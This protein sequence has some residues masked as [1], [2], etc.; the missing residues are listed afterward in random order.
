MKST[1]AFK[2]YKSMKQFNMAKLKY[3]IIISIFW[4]IAACGDSEEECQEASYASNITIM[5]D[6]I[7][8]FDDGVELQ[9]NSLNNEFC[10]CNVQCVAAGFISIDMVWT[11]ADGTTLNLTHNE[12]MDAIPIPTQI[13]PG[14][15]E[16][17]ADID[18]II[19]ERECSN[20][21]PQ[22]DIESVVIQ[23]MN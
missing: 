23:V 1:Y 5:E 13:P 9:I 22:P 17:T 8:C 12:T 14:N 6:D 7:L 20:I 15:F 19:F 3:L 2:I 18:S 4:T 11:L 16:I 10:P 21:N